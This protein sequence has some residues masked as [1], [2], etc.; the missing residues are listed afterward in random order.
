MSSSPVTKYNVFVSSMENLLPGTKDGKLTK[1]ELQ[2]GYDLLLAQGSTD[3]PPEILERFKDGQALADQFE[4]RGLLTP[5]DGY[6]D[7]AELS[8]Y[9]SFPGNPSLPPL[10]PLIPLP[11][12]VS[13]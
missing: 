11:P 9:A 1:A 8:V 13:S 3:I 2:E 6:E 7:G 12:T 5:K 4:S 10:P